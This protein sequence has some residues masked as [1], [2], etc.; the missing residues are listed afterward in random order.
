MAVG[1]FG[2][3]TNFGMALLLLGAV[4]SA[5]A[6]SVT[7]IEVAPPGYAASTWSGKPTLAHEIEVPL[8]LGDEPGGARVMVDAAASTQV[9]VRVQFETS[10]AVGLEGPHIDLLDFRHCQSAWVPATR[11]DG[12]VFIVPKPTQAQESCIPEATVPEVR[13]ALRKQLVRMGMQDSMQTWL[14]AMRDVKRVGD[15][16]TYVALGRVRVLV[17]AKAGGKWKRQAVLVLRVPMG[18]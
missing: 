14:D 4:S 11:K 3:T 8:E 10:I 16:P 9:R 6:Q 12:R 2:R 15:D 1:T 18:C 13:E 17:E 7:R 5:W